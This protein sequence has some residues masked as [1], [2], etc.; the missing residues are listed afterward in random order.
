[1][2]VADWPCFSKYYVTFPLDSLPAGQVIHSATLTLHEFGGSQPADAQASLIQVMSVAEDWDEGTLTW[3]NAPQVFE[4]VSQTWVDPL[5]DFPGWPGVPFH[6]DLSRAVAQ[7]YAS[8]QPLRIVLYSADA[9][10]H[11]GK[12]F[13]SS[14]AE[15]WNATARPTLNISWGTP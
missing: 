12:Y 8:G 3:N 10:M 11:S 2:D 13:S 1:M 5:P 15:D 4:N 9:A 14:D 6:W 7:A